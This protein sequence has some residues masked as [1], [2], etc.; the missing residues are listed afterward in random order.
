MY[1]V[2]NFVYVLD[3]LFNI[4]NIYNLFDISLDII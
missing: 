1:G 2:F 3:A 4:R